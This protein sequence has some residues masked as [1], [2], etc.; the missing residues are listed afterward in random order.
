[1]KGRILVVGEDE[2]EKYVDVFFDSDLIKGYYLTDEN[3]VDSSV[4]IITGDNSITL[5]Q[6]DELKEFLIK[7]NW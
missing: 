1:M 7:K 3:Y 4:N 6:S 2:K 5:K